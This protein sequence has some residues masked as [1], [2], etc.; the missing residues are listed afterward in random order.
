MTSYVEFYYTSNFNAYDELFAWLS[1][2]DEIDWMVLEVKHPPNFHV[3]NLV[4]FKGMYY[5]FTTVTDFQYFYLIFSFLKECSF[6]SMCQTRIV[7][8]GFILPYII[9]ALNLMT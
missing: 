5:F 4:L 2:T 7:P 6:T 9:Q 8:L 1:N 3:G